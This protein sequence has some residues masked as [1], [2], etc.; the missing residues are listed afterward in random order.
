MS[1]IPH[2]SLLIYLCGLEYTLG[3]FNQR[4]RGLGCIFFL[5]EQYVPW[6]RRPLE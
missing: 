3:E 1:I 4:F 6:W 2:K 5:D